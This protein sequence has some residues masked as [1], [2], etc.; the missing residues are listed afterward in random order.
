M[1]AALS[2]E[3]PGKETVEKG[4]LKV[5]FFLLSLGCNDAIQICHVSL[6]SGSRYPNLNIIF[7]GFNSF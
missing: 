7:I 4:D 6:T 3:H 2:S 5:G 1:R